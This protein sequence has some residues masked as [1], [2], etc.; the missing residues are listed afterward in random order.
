MQRNATLLEKAILGSTE[1]RSSDWSLEEMTSDVDGNDEER[2]RQGRV[3]IR[4]SSNNRQKED[5]GKFRSN[6]QSLSPVFDDHRRGRDGSFESKHLEE[7]SK[8]RS[9]DNVIELEDNTG[10]ESS[11]SQSNNHLP[12]LDVE[13]KY[14]A[15]KKKERRERQKSRD[16]SIRKRERE[17]KKPYYLQVNYCGK[18]LGDG[19]TAWKVDINKLSKALDPSMMDVREQPP[20]EMATLRR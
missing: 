3:G 15:I 17:G 13:T 2:R 4:S 16:K 9:H 14:E 12:E 19:V 1:G 5:I 20:I 18:P 8:K 11:G 7:G 6:R 10:S